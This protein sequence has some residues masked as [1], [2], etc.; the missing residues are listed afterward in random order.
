M[1]PE[2][3]RRKAQRV[4]ARLSMEV[5]LESEGA[6]RKKVETLNVSTNGVYFQLDRYIEPMTKIEMSLVIPEAEGKSKRVTCQ[7]IVVRTEPEIES[8]EIDEYNIACFFTY[9]READ[10]DLLESFILQHLP[11]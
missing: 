11:L 7:G 1:I 6:G 8:P 2:N 3:E 9:I 10:L 5:S 4:E